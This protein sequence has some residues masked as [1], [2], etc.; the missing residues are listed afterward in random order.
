MKQIPASFKA[1][2]MTATG[3]SMFTPNSTS[4]SA[5]PVLLV[6]LRLPCFATEIPAAAATI[7][8]AV[9]MLN[10]PL[11]SP[12]VPHVSTRSWRSDVIVVMCLRIARAAPATSSA[13]SPFS[14]S[15]SNKEAIW[16]SSHCPLITRSITS[17]ISAI[18]RSSPEVTFPI[19]VVNIC[20]LYQKGLRPN[21]GI[22]SL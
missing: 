17:A 3:A 11:P 7:A 16:S 6:I 20:C 2:S 1:C 4:T 13:V 21:L 9:L 8:A 22:P 5:D 14:L 18:V 10:V 12:P 19:A 15:F